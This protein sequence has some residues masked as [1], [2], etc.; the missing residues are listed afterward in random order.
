[1][2]KNKIQIN[3]SIVYKKKKNL[4]YDSVAQITFK[5]KL[6]SINLNIDT[7]SN[8]C[9]KNIKLFGD[10]G[11][12]FWERKIEKNYE[13]IEIR[14]SKNLDYKFFKLTRRDDFINQ[15][16]SLLFKKKGYNNLSN[17]KLGSAVEVMNI[18]KKIFKHV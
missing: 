2:F 15:I 5:D 7:V 1:M 10:K 17:I 12:I 3:Q 13:K 4:Y 16:R 14:K 11:T 8:P 18:L 9:Q 6:R